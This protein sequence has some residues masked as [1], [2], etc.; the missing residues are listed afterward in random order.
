VPH[1]VLGELICACVVP[2]EGAVVTG[3]D[4]KDYARETLANYKTPDLVRFFDRF[5]MTRAGRSGG[6]NSSAWSRSTHS[7]TSAAVTRARAA[8]GR[9]RRP[10]GPA[11]ARPRRPPRGPSAAREPTT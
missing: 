2:V 5:P 8:Y 7:V 9:G 11:P 3:K 10:R 1:D 4:V 6:E